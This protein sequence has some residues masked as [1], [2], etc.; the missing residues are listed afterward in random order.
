MGRRYKRNFLDQVICR[1]DFPLILRL[2]KESPIEF[3][4]KIKHLFPKASE[5]VIIGAKVGEQDPL[6]VEVREPAPR[7]EFY[8]R[9]LKK[10]LILQSQFLALEDHEFASFER[11][12]DFCFP[13]IDALNSIYGPP[14]FTRLGLRYINIVELPEGDPLDWDGFFDR[15]LTAH[16][17]FE[18]GCQLIDTLQTIRLR[19]K[20]TTTV[21]R[22]GL[23]N[24]DAP[25]PVKR[26]RFVLDIDCFLKQDFETDDVKAQLLLLNEQAVDIFERSIDDSLR[27]LMEEGE[28]G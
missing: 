5:A 15:R 1:V 11:F 23:Q 21:I 10:K 14:L 26:R 7:W 8:T 6:S 13:A 24:P 25:S 9:N 20:H 28:I 3:Q 22:C 12:E 19:K 27:E 17:Q 18:H 2:K 16:L 4:E